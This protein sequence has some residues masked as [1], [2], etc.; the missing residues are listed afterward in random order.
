MTHSIATMVDVLRRD[1]GSIGLVSG[2]GMHMTKH[3]F[4][5]Y[6]TD[7]ARLGSP[8]RSP[9]APE[10]VDRRE[11]R[12]ASSGKARVAAYSI[13]HDRDGTPRHGVAVCDLP[14]GARTYAT[15]TDVDLLDD[16]E[17]HE[18]VGSTVRLQPQVMH[19]ARGS[20]RICNVLRAD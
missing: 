12:A 17:H 20:S 11:I 16:G 18:M 13:V 9:S 10:N 8:S 2:V 1:P 14:D 15:I 7:P 5:V 3:L 19:D 6:S 4:A